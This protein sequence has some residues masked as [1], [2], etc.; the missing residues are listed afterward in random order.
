MHHFGVRSDYQ[1]KSLEA[2]SYFKLL[3]TLTED[4]LELQR[5]TL[6]TNSRVNHPRNKAIR[7]KMKKYASS[8]VINLLTCLHLNITLHSS[9]HI[10]GCVISFLY[11]IC[12]YCSLLWELVLFSQNPILLWEICLFFICHT[13]SDSIVLLRCFLLLKLT[14]WLYHR[15]FQLSSAT[16]M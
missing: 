5:V 3:L 6:W 12:S 15:F 16:P 4:A 13:C 11:T 10:P 14:L 8:Q 1:I 9:Q 7:I 2:T